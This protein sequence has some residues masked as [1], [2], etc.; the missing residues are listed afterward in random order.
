MRDASDGWTPSLP[1]PQTREAARPQRRLAGR[2]A[3]VNAGPAQ[4]ARGP[5][6]SGT[7]AFSKAN[8]DV[9]LQSDGDG[10]KVPADVP[11]AGRAKGSEVWD[12][13]RISAV[14]D[15]WF[16]MYAADQKS[17]ASPTLSAELFLRH[18]TAA[19]EHLGVPNPLLG[20]TSCL[21]L[22]QLA[23]A[24]RA[25]KGSLLSHLHRVIVDC[26]YSSRSQSDDSAL[27]LEMSFN[28][29]L[30]LPS[31]HDRFKGMRESYLRYYAMAEQT[32]K[33]LSRQHLVFG[34]TI[35]TWQRM[36][37]ARYFCAWHLTA[38]RHRRQRSVMSAFHRTKSNRHVLQS[39]LTRWVAVTALTKERAKSST[40][41]QRE[42]SGK[43]KIVGLQDT[44]AEK[45]GQMTAFETERTL[46]EEE[47]AEL[48]ETV[49]AKN[50]AI[51]RQAARIDSLEAE[52]SAFR[53]ALAALAAHTWPSVEEPPGPFLFSEIDTDALEA[54]ADASPEE[55]QIIRANARMIRRHAALIQQ[56][57]PQID[58]SVP[59]AA[60]RERDETKDALSSFQ[61]ISNSPPD[62]PLSPGARA[63]E[64]EAT[65]AGV[66]ARR[67][68]SALAA[69]PRRA[70]HAA[71]HKAPFPAAAA[72]KVASLWLC[73]AVF[74]S[75]PCAALPPHLPIDFRD[76]SVLLSLYEAV[77]G[78]YDS[79][80]K[81]ALL[82]DLSFNSRASK[83]IARFQQWLDAC[84]LP[85]VSG[86]NVCLQAIDVAEPT[87]DQSVL[88]LLCAVVER[89]LSP[90]AGAARP[91]TLDGGAPA[92]HPRH[93][94][95]SSGTGKTGH[96]KRKKSKP[97]AR[98]GSQ[99]STASI[100]SRTG[101]RQSRDDEGDAEGGD[102]GKGSIRGPDGS[103]T[104]ADR[105]RRSIIR[106]SM[107]G[108]EAL[109]GVRAMLRT[110]AAWKSAIVHPLQR[111]RAD[112]LSDRLQQ[113][114]D[115]ALESG[116]KRRDRAQLLT[117]D[118]S[119]L[120]GL[121]AKA[122][123]TDGEAQASVFEDLRGSLGRHSS[124]LF[125]VWKFYTPDTRCMSA[126]S[127]WRFTSDLRLE[128]AGGVK[129]A[130]LQRIYK[131]ANEETGPGATQQHRKSKSSEP[132][133]P[134]HRANS[135]RK[136]SVSSSRLQ[137]ADSP[138]KRSA[139]PVGRGSKQHA[140]D[141]RD[142][143]QH[144]AH[145]GFGAWSPEL[146]KDG[147]TRQ[148]FASPA[149]SPRNDDPA[150]L[151]PAGGGGG[152]KHA[153]FVEG[154]AVCDGPASNR[155]KEGS[156]P[157]R[158]SASLLDRE[159]GAEGHDGAP[160]EAADEYNPADELTAAEWVDCIVHI[161]HA[162]ASGPGDPQPGCL[163]LAQCLDDFVEGLMKKYACQ[164]NVDE[165]RDQI[166]RKDVQA[167][168]SRHNKAL[169]AVF[170]F[171]SAFDSSKAKPEDD[172]DISFHEFR[173]LLRDAKLLDGTLTLEAAQELFKFMQQD[174]GAASDRGQTLVYREFLEVVVCLA[175]FKVPAPFIKLADRLHTF[176]SSKL[177]PPLKHA[178]P[179][180][181]LK[182]AKPGDRDCL[183]L[184]QCL[185]DDDISFHEYRQLLRD[186]SL[187]D[188][189]LTLE[190]AQELFKFMQQDDGG[191]DAAR[192]NDAP[193]L[194]DKEAGAESH[195]GDAAPG[196]SKTRPTN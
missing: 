83:I 77:T 166:Y 12:Y 115:E 169:Q 152:G 57:Y 24:E 154:D 112:Q 122:Q 95:A 11:G 72:M 196:T 98:S 131:Q 176:V 75:N 61:F 1:R 121:F 182:R 86:A 96:A 151:A 111:A 180:L 132:A 65:F 8:V 106:G 113:A 188:G 164:S 10:L 9:T 53:G 37:V 157:P 43:A 133:E 171:Y 15:R 23:Q 34:R 195:C 25:G 63:P 84:P 142:T 146:G 163:N 59:A 51:E 85:A 153:S 62:H 138:D 167:V 93:K 81:E 147:E 191:A 58:A 128:K 110:V 42:A 99:A 39:C 193:P 104:P 87:S 94:R 177:L 108:A 36:L 92:Q 14:S 90:A 136:Q 40:F 66:V 88:P 89:W 149:D 141:R 6:K 130:V 76:S 33:V 134:P 27:P 187:L 71:A 103:W 97:R 174:D 165:F 181:H 159:A 22:H 17:F 69:A 155:G 30:A 60:E 162:V 47:I 31:W 80:F 123:L 55:R 161:A 29:Y 82:A 46:L 79:R 186:T 26:I 172:D 91:K 144:A 118:I 52:C 139:K 140:G 129:R 168:L 183:N 109:Q 56:Q 70:A 18:A 4:K 160:G 68:S 102:G 107:S 137:S 16:E 28:S 50:A 125:R 78:Q 184:A 38:H 64:D 19:S 73:R 7:S 170:K 105:F 145:E 67:P 114:G 13:E 119:R 116:A 156:S 49:D 32:S 192:F 190:A 3:A 185:D 173:Q 120:R 74:A 44:L 189:T 45:Q 194:L 101:R 54:A 21:V 135:I 143:A 2:W 117:I 150:R 124:F 178:Q 158:R 41:L 5:F 48:K 35:G 179:K 175:I 100:C 20:A 148:T 126:P 127:Y